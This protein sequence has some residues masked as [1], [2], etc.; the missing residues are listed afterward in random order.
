MNPALRLFP[1]VTPNG[2]VSEKFPVTLGQLFD[3]TGAP[4]LCHATASWSLKR[5]HLF[6]EQDAVWLLHEYGHTNAIV[7]NSREKN[8]NEVM[9]LCGVQYYLVRLRSSSTLY[10][11]SLTDFNIPG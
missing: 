4:A 3:M 11:A 2:V 8:V 5:E 6:T 1:L 10:V 7:S 9:R